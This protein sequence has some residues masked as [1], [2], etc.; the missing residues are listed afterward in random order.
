MNPKIGEWKLALKGIIEGF[1]QWYMDSYYTGFIW[2]SRPHSVFIACPFYARKNP[3]LLL[4][5]TLRAAPI[6]RLWW[7]SL[8]LFFA[9]VGLFMLLKLPTPENL[10]F[11]PFLYRLYLCK[12]G[13]F[14][15]PL[16]LT[17]FLVPALSFF[18]RITLWGKNL[19]QVKT[20]SD[21]NSFLLTM[22]YHHHHRRSWTQRHRTWTTLWGMT[23]GFGWKPSADS[24]SFL[25]TVVSSRTGRSWRRRHRTPT[26]LWSMVWPPDSVENHHQTYLYKTRNT[27]FHSFSNASFTL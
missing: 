10:G 20:I 17:D 23:T 21:C 12:R 22:W 1:V 11:Q 15:T 6:E 5:S 13:F 19:W 7:K 14:L 25:L 26:S 3:A 9:V 16:F 18:Y 24:N 8:G 27:V 4:F 2:L